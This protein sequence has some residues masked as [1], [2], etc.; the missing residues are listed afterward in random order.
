MSFEIRPITED[1]IEMFRTK[2]SRG[3]GG[4]LTDKDEDGTKRFKAIVPLARTR[5]AFEGSQMI[6]TLACLPFAL[7]VPGGAVEM[8]G[9]TMVT[10]QPTHRRRGA[11]RQMMLDHLEDVRDAGEPVAGLWASESSIYGRFGFGAATERHEVELDAESIHFTERASVGEIELIEADDAAEALPPIYER[12]RATRPGALGRTQ[13]YWKWS[14]LYDPERWRD[15]M[16]ARRYV[17]HHGP[18]GADGYAMYR[19]KEKWE[20]FLAEGK[21]SVVETFALTPGAHH[22]L[23]SYLTNIDL[24]PN[25][26]YWNQPVDDELAWRITDPRR[27]VRK[28]WDALWLRIIDIPAAL[29]ARSYGVDGELRVGIADDLFPENSGTFEISSSAG[30]SS[31]TRVDGGAELT[32]GVDVLAS[33]YL[34]GHSLG[35]AARAGR[36]EG[37]AEAIRRADGFFAW[38]PAPW[39]PEI[40]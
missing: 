21:V 38:D 30:E 19:Q 34:G 29:A 24:F 18:D 4:D 7:T 10:V 6:G 27:V 35:A 31:C 1:E 2:L 22:A 11:L 40:F 32:M 20:G 25:V 12:L 16:S 14:V 23:W 15:G 28:V 37:G 13:D 39:C 33:A 5:A 36:V 3:F 9:T 8:G 26:K 17:L